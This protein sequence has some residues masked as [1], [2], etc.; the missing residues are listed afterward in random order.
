MSY[1]ENHLVFASRDLGETRDL[2]SNLNAIDQFDIIG[3]GASMDTVIH[4]ACF[5]DL[6]LLYASFGDVRVQIETP[7]SENN[8]L[9]LLAVTNGG[10][11]VHHRGQ[12]FDL[13]LDRGLIR[14]MRMPLFAYEENFAC[15]GMELPV[16]LL[17]QQV[18][19]LIGDA[20]L[21]ID[22]KFGTGIDF[23]TV[24]GRHVRDTLHYIAHALDGPLVDLDNAILLDSL[25]DMLLINILMQ[26]PN[27]FSDLLKYQ[28]A[29]RAVPHYVKRARDYIHEYADRSI[30]LEKLVSHAGCSYRTLQVAFNETYG[31]APMAYLRNVRLA[32]AHLDLLNAADG[33]TVAEIAIKWGFIHLGRFSQT[34]A[35][36]FG[37][38]PSETLRRRH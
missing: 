19:A 3:S 2:L 12:E 5:S 6:N 14:D 26:L 1:L 36:Q 7:E 28:T 4:T 11:K 32:K 29:S 21:M 38:L 8:S 20:A 17:R 37:V 13:S 10:G 34:Y 24:G 27:S 15:L 23:K 33:M 9:F 22:L 16:R 31:M 35:K 25:R 18:H 30:T